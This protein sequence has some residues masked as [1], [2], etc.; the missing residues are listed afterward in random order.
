MKEKSEV[1]IADEEKRHNQV[2]FTSC[3]KTCQLMMQQNL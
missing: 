1:I 3:P 2:C